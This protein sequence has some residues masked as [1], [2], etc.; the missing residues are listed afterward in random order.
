MIRFGTRTAN[1]C[2]AMIVALVADGNPAQFVGSKR[3]LA[4]TTADR[5]TLEQ[6]AKGQRIAISI[7]G[8]QPMIPKVTP[9]I[10]AVGLGRCGVCDALRGDPCR[11]SGNA[12]RHPHKGRT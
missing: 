7:L 12:T 4:V 11:T 8:A 5:V 6:I 3:K 9:V 2:R 1:D 10:A